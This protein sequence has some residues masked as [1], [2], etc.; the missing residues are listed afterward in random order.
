MEMPFHR[1]SITEGVSFS[2]V[3]DPKFKHNRLSINMLMPL[4]E[5]KLSER[6]I[7]PF[8][9]RQGTEKYPNFTK[10]NEKLSDLYGASLEASV[11]KYGSYQLL[12]LGMVGIDSRFAFEGEDMVKEL[13]ELLADILLEPA[14]EDGVFSKNE[15]A[16]EKEYIRDTIEAE[17]NEK[18]AYALLRCKTIMS[19]GEKL[20]LRKFGTVEEVE[21]ITPESAYNAYK[22]ILDKSQIEIVMTGCGCPESAC[23]QFK[24]RFAGMKRNPIKV[25]IKNCRKLPVEKQKDFTEKIDVKQGKLVLG[26]RMDMDC[27]EEEKNAARLAIALLGNTPTCLLFKNVR[28]KLSLCYYC[29]A[30]LD[31]ITG[32]M[33]VDSGVEAE[34]CEKAKDEILKQLEILKSG[35]FEENELV[36]TKLFMKTALRSTGDSLGALENWYLSRVLSGNAKSPEETM[37]EILKIT[38]EQ[39]VSAA[40]KLELDTVYRLLPKDEISDEEGVD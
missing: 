29:A 39:I 31:T 25:D 15:T 18:R 4:E 2:W 6:A 23:E 28:E 7:V 27:S 1:V 19:E 9:L 11:D 30:R 34:N 33:L 37:E 26:F 24:K 13:A 8:I 3:Q 14:L 40:G 36:E 16:L 10:L 32:I 17:I 21:K 5:G 12:T 35:D 20:A 22:E 38:K